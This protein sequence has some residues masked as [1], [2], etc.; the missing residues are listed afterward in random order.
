MDKDGE[1]IAGIDLDRQ[2]ANS[3]TSLV[4][5]EPPAINTAVALIAGTVARIIDSLEGVYDK[6]EL[7]IKRRIDTAAQD[8]VPREEIMGIRAKMKAKVA[9]LLHGVIDSMRRSR[10]LESTDLTKLPTLIA[11]NSEEDLRTKADINDI[12]DSRVGAFLPFLDEMRVI[13]TY[14]FGRGIS[15]EKL[16]EYFETDQILDVMISEL[17]SVEDSRFRGTSVYALIRSL[18]KSASRKLKTLNVRM[19]KRPV[20]D[21][22]EEKMKRNIAYFTSH[23][24]PHDRENTISRFAKELMQTYHEYDVADWLKKNRRLL[25]EIIG[26]NKIKH[27]PNIIREVYE[28]CGRTNP[29]K[30]IE[31]NMPAFLFQQT[32]GGDFEIHPTIRKKLA[33]EGID[34]PHVFIDLEQLEYF[35]TETMPRIE[36]ERN[37]LMALRSGIVDVCMTE[38]ELT[39]VKA[40]VSRGADLKYNAKKFE[41]TGELQDWIRQT[42]TYSCRVVSSNVDV[43]NLL[44]DPLDV[45][46]EI[47]RNYETCFNEEGKV[48]EKEYQKFLIRLFGHTAI[49]EEEGTQGKTAPATGEPS[50]LIAR[51]EQFDKI[52]KRIIRLFKEADNYVDSVIAKTGVVPMGDIVLEE[53]KTTNDY[54]ELIRIACKDPSSRKRFE[55]RRKIEL[56]VLI[57]NCLG[58]QRYVNQDHDAMAVRAVLESRKDRLQTV[59]TG[60]IRTVRFLDYKDGTTKILGKKERVANS[61]LYEVR[62]EQLIPANFAGEKCY[63]IPADNGGA[64]GETSEREYVSEKTLNSMLTN[65]INDREKRGAKDL[66]DLIRMTFVVDD[67]NKFDV[68]RRHIERGYVGFG[69]TLKREDRYGRVVRVQSIGTNKAKADE[70]KALRYVVDIPVEGEGGTSDYFVPVEIRILYMEDFVIEKSRY[71]P[72]SHAKYEERRLGQVL[73]KLAPEEIYPG[74]YKIILPHKDDISCTAHTVLKGKEDYSTAP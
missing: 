7:G 34:E 55:A 64:G 15:S 68:I 19:G 30:F 37:N 56:A 3:Q 1:K 36:T 66:T 33:R 42:V 70:Y 26:G 53:T 54:A 35:F 52:R 39:G 18:I 14:A 50:K 40:V 13:G 62:E 48:D 44:V 20:T 57:Y 32:N 24:D 73:E 31:L 63:L 41:T 16:I 2:G 22:L 69:M 27:V 29:K 60:Q 6:M 67:N 10:V 74:A 25:K 4:E 5:Y 21:E 58:T 12:L 45:P 17:L 23:Y 47:K 43:G 11:T 28:E 46:D 8:E 61:D 59:R 49:V 72:A 65:L 51:V 9:R 38:I 71:H